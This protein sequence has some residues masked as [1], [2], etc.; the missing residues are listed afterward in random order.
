V[1]SD[2]DFTAII[3]EH[4]QA[5]RNFLRRLSGDWAEA[6]DLA[7]DVFITAWQNAARFRDGGNVKT[8]LCGIAYRKFL[9]ARRGLLRRWRRDA[10]AIEGAAQSVTP[11]DAAELRIDL[12]RALQALPI[13]QRAVIVL[14]L[15]EGATQEEAAAILAL[16]LGTV[17]SHTL[18]GRDKLMAALGG[19]NG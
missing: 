18:R 9:T 13:E 4:H 14:C 11:G 3:A 16:P 12:V 7:Q 10:A 8:W 5:V 6:D 1:P 17:K 19:S 15:G 2:A